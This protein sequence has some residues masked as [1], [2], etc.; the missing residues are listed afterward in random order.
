MK[1]LLYS[2][3]SNF[4]KVIDKAK[5]SCKLSSG[6]IQEHFAEVGKLLTVGN[7]AKIEVLDYHLTRYACYLIVQNGD[8]RKKW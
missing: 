1:V 5:A 6:N 2:K 8:S 4:R 7:D 3:W